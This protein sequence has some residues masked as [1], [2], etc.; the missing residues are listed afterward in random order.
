MLLKE[1]RGVTLYIKQDKRGSKSDRANKFTESL[2]SYKS[3]NNFSF[4]R[5]HKYD[6]T[7]ILEIISNLV[8]VEILQN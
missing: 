2:N 1:L 4:E 5:Q 8:K 6:F 3:K 7:G